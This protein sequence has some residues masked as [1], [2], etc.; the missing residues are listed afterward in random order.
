M[1]GQIEVESIQYE[2]GAAYVCFRVAGLKSVKSQVPI[3]SGDIEEERIPIT[4]KVEN[5]GS[6]PSPSAV[7]VPA[8]RDLACMIS[9]LASEANEKLKAVEKGKWPFCSQE[10]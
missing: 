9:S 4:K 8:M 1:A 3:L 7:I 10:D 5:I 2:E 6:D